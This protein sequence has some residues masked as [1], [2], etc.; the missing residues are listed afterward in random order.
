MKVQKS[1][2]V[3]RLCG[4]WEITR[5]DSGRRRMDIHLKEHRE[6][7][8][9]TGVFLSEEDKSEEPGGA[10]QETVAL[11]SGGLWLEKKPGAGA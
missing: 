3:G 5:K 10:E 1:R 2:E 4:D 6:L 11:S 7:S 8:K 9:G